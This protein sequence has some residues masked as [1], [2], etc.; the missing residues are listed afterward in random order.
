MKNGQIKALELEIDSLKA[1]LK[2]KE[3]ECKIL[4]D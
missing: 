3:K 1:S 4:E 2:S